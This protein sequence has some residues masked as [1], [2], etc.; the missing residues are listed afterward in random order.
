MKFAYTRLVTDDVAGLAAFYEQLLGVEPKGNADYVEL[1]PQGAILAIVSAKAATFLHGG[2]WTGGAN[3]SVI[4]EFE[5][6]DVDAE[7]GRI[8]VFVTDWVQQPKDMPWGNR[9]MLFRDPDGNAIN[10]FKPMAKT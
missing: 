7:R 6:A 2:A 8:D 1:H 3:K 4:L 5:V 9:S 10:F